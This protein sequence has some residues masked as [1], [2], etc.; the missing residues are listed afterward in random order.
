MKN[1]NLN[2]GSGVSNDFNCEFNIATDEAD[3]D[4]ERVFPCRSNPEVKVALE[5]LL[6]CRMVHV[7]VAGGI[8]RHN[9]W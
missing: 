3:S 8:V 5:S 4:S 1:D 6:R 2:N 9:F 7:E